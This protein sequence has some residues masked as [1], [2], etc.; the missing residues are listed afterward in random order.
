M[1]CE[2]ISVPWCLPMRRWTISLRAKS[3][4]LCWTLCE[5][6][7]KVFQLWNHLITLRWKLAIFEMNEL[8]DS[9]NLLCSSLLN[10]VFQSLQKRRWCEIH[11]SFHSNFTLFS[12]FFH[13][14]NFTFKIIWKLVLSSLFPI[15]KW[16]PAALKIFGAKSFSEHEQYLPRPQSFFLNYRVKMGS[17]LILFISSQCTFSSL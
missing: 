12:L 7:F 1:T 14:K 9:V 11:I 3:L 6:T 8:C 13:F 17:D 4:N 10:H 16:S 5:M 2:I 15:S